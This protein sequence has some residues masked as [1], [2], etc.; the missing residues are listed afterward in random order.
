[1]RTQS[2]GLQFAVKHKGR[3]CS[4]GTQQTSEQIARSKAILCVRDLGMGTI[5]SCNLC[6][7]PR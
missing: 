1:M 7:I 6:A 3:C 5:A 4:L 2:S